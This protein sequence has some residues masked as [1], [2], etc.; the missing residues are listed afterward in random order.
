MDF[1]KLS[2][3]MAVAKHEH[4]TNAANE[5]NISQPAL[6]RIIS[7]IEEELGVKL[8]DR[9]GRQL[10]LNQCGKAFLTFCT[11]TLLDYKDF[12]AEIQEISSGEGGRLAVAVSFPYR[13][14]DWL[15]YLTRAFVRTHPGVSFLLDNKNLD[16]IKQ[17]LYERETDIAL[18]DVPVTGKN[19]LWRDLFSENI[20]V[21]LSAEHPLAKKSILC[22]DDLRNEKFLCNN[23]SSENHDYTIGICAKA[24]FSPD[25]CFR[26]T[27]PDI[28]GE[29]VSQGKGIA[30][31]H[32]GGF[33]GYSNLRY[34]WEYNLV[35]RPLSNDYCVR[36]YGIATLEDRVLPAAVQ[37]FYD[38]LVSTN[39]PELRHKIGMKALQRSRPSETETE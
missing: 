20:G 21:L 29:A 15:Q 1:Q 25:I 38:S 16:Q 3:F 5:M 10:H 18:S 12:Q 39:I 8:F 22:M 37:D 24:G 33:K 32:E 31:M 4:I 34:D 28:I 6:S 2:Y 7:Q 11:R 13:E 26:G 9:G 30:L 17:S 36:T 27:F 23:T 14:P 35:F 19:I